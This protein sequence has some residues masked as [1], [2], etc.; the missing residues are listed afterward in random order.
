MEMITATPATP[1]ESPWMTKAE[2]AAYMRVDTR[3]IDR[4]VRD[5][6]LTR[7]RV[8]GIQSVRFARADLEGLLTAEPTPED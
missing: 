7:H 1:A 3:T 8:S 4:W 5:G 2:A 6:K